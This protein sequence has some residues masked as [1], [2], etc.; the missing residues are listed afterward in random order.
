MAYPITDDAAEL[1]W[2]FPQQL[3]TDTIHRW[4]RDT[5]FASWQDRLPEGSSSRRRCPADKFGLL[6]VKEDARLK[7]VDRAHRPLLAFHCDRVFIRHDGE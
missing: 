1:P 5:V 3:A 4:P 2:L 6:G 7:A